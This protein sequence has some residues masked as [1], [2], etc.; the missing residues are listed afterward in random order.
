M[1]SRTDPAQLTAD[2]VGSVAEPKQEQPQG[3][4]ERAQEAAGEAQ[5]KIRDQVDRRSTEIGEQVAASASALR[6]G[7]EELYRQGNHQVG[8]M[9]QRAA[10]QAER[11]G[12]Y[13]QSADADRLLSDA[14]DMARRN[15]WTVVVG[16]VAVGAVA[17]RFLKASST[18]RFEQTRGLHRYEQSRG[19]RSYE[20]PRSS[21]MPT[22]PVAGT[23]L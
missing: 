4:A 14:E 17:A 12:S 11:L 22:S 19:I 10:S 7:A 20:P 21:S 16:G 2:P 1:N 15:P 9:A 3:V 13:L 23:P 6:S 8:D 5:V 18:R